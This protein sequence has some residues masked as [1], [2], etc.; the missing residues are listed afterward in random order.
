MVQAVVAMNVALYEGGHLTPF[1]WKASLAQAR[2]LQSVSP[3][4]NPFQRD[5][6]VKRPDQETAARRLPWVIT[7]CENRKWEADG[8]DLDDVPMATAE[9]REKIIGVEWDDLT[10]DMPDLI[11]TALEQAD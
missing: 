2:R 11:K 5:F 8:L 4:G 10:G 7:H 6:L 1:I 3:Q 9:D